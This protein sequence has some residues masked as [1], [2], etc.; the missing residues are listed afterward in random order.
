LIIP[1]FDVSQQTIIG[2][3]ELYKHHQQAFTE[4]IEGRYDFFSKLVSDFFILYAQLAS[5]TM[6]IGQ[7]RW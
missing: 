7:L 4:E 1:L 6:Q 3:F 2:S 5:Q